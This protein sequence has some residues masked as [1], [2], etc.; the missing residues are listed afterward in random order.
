MSGGLDFTPTA[1]QNSVSAN[2]ED[3][4]AAMKQQQSGLSRNDQANSQVEQLD[5]EFSQLR[6]ANKYKQDHV[7]EP[8]THSMPALGTQH[9]PSVAARESVGLQ[10]L[11]EREIKAA[12]EAEMAKLQA[13][14]E[15]HGA[16]NERGRMARNSYPGRSLSLR[17]QTMTFR[18]IRDEAA[19]CGMENPHRVDQISQLH[20]ELE[21]RDIDLDQAH[22][23]NRKLKVEKAACVAAHERDVASLESMN[24]LLMD[25]NKMLKAA[26][27]EA[28]SAERKNL[29]QLSSRVI[30]EAIER[31]IVSDLI[32]SGISNVPSTPHSA[33]SASTE[34]PPFEPEAEDLDV[35]RGS[36][37]QN[38]T[39]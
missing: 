29:P 33:A 32:Q 3:M 39:P 18:D 15:A 1:R 31:N 30:S 24:T 21:R 17:P 23:E 4:L 22:I 27:S 25:E 9:I 38:S 8:L 2:L 35:S 12:R 10:D 14:P 28:R 13:I 5:R 26:L 19:R 11:V 34:T 16:L 36:I 7:Q 37:F 20:R 6:A